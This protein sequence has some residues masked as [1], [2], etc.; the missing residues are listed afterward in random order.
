MAVRAVHE[1]S[2]CGR[3]VPALMVAVTTPWLAVFTTARG[4]GRLL[5]GP[6]IDRALRQAL[7][8]LGYPGVSAGCRPVL[9][10]ASLPGASSSRRSLLGRVLRLRGGEAC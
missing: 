1:W 3:V 8:M 9:L 10:G 6:A 4:L 5:Q 7:G 2:L